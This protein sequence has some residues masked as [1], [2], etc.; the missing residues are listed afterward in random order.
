VL[1]F[2]SA[3]F[4]FTVLCLVV[5][6]ALAEQ[7]AANSSISFT[8][9]KAEDT[10]GGAWKITVTGTATLGM[11][12]TYQ[13]FRCDF[14]DPNNNKF[15]GILNFTPPAPGKSSPFTFWYVAGSP[16]TW[17]YS[18]TMYWTTGQVPGLDGR[19]GTVEVG[20]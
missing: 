16:G 15:A 9:A 18:A 20:Q 12:D 8:G 3:L 4:T 5:G 6:I 11:N 19:G 1:R 13:G 14:T 2:L 17:G 7:G 10:G